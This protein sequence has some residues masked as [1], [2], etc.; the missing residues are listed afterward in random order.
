M[1]IWISWI[2]WYA[3]PHFVQHIRADLYDKMHAQS[4]LM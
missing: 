3:N 4:E 1:N 2:H